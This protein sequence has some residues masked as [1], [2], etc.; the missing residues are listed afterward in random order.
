[1]IYNF[2][3]INGYQRK[4]NYKIFMNNNNLY[5][6]SNDLRSISGLESLINKDTNDLR[7]IF[8]LESLI[9]KY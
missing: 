8:G 3:S 9:N 6:I 7:S 4:E 5:W 2:I 1:M